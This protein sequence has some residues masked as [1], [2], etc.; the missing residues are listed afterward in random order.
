M[1]TTAAATPLFSM[2]VSTKHSKFP[3]FV[4]MVISLLFVA[5]GVIGLL[6]GS[7]TSS[8][9]N[10]LNKMCPIIP[11]GGTPY[12]DTN[13]CSLV[14]TNAAEES[15]N[16]STF[17]LIAFSAILVVAFILIGVNVQTLMK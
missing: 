11:S 5:V 2:P 1:S 10:K 17:S 3:A 4:T 15:K 13:P 8:V 16:I 14:T 6:A 7:Y 12:P 9:L